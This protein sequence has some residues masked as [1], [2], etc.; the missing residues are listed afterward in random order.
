MTVMTPE[1]ATHLIRSYGGVV[2]EPVS[3]TDRGLMLGI[4]GE[5]GVGKTTLAATIADS[6]L[7]RPALLLDARGNPHVISSYSDRVDVAT[8]TRFDQVDKIRQDILRDKN[9]PYKS[10]ILDNVTEMWSMDL[11][12]RYGP[13][14]SVEW[15]KHAASTSDIVQLVRNWSDLALTGLKLNV[16]FV[17]QETPETR[18]IQG[19][20][21]VVRS[22]VAFN[23]ALQS[24]VPTL[25]NFLGRLYQTSDQPPYRRKLDFRPIMTMH[26]AKLQVDRDDEYAK[27]IPFEMHDPSLASIL[28]TIRGHKPFPIEKH[29]APVSRR[30]Q[31]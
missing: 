13:M 19:R 7:G 6:D 11:R 23:K 1:N 26:Q 29:S 16:I 4:Y 18:D 22:E 24:H 31:P 28:D 10:V 14:V 21:G 5:G 17:F 8:V 30:Q 25:V 27:Q 3:N 15:T 20:T 2:V 9:L 12:D